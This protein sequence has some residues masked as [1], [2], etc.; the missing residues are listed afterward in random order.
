MVLGLVV[1]ILVIEKKCWV[2]IL[3]F[4]LEVLGILILLELDIFKLSLEN[5]GVLDYLY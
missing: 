1:G 2:V 4:D 3:D 5:Y